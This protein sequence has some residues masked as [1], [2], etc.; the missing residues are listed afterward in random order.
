VLR[1]RNNK[2]QSDFL[3]QEYCNDKTTRILSKI[4]IVKN[5]AR[6][7][8]V[9]LFI[10]E[11]IKTPAVQFQEIAQALNDE[12][13]AKSNETRIQDFFREVDL[14]YE[15]VSI[16]LTFFLPRW[17]KIT[18]CIDLTEWDLGKKTNSIF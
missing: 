16:L 17:G 6:K 9:I 15:K 11:M 3:L 14:D 12:V 1:M 13:K 7:R 18:L 5:K 2:N 10:L 8:F 4:P